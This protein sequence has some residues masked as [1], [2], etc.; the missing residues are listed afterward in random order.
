MSLSSLRSSARRLRRP[1]LLLCAGALFS[2]CEDAPT[3]ASPLRAIDARP[4]MAFSGDGAVEL[5]LP[6][7][8]WQAEGF[9]VNDAGDVVGVS[10]YLDEFGGGRLRATLWRGTGGAPVELPEFPGSNASEAMSI[11]DQGDIVGRIWHDDLG[12]N[13]VIWPAGGAPRALPGLSSQV[14]NGALGLSNTEVVGWSKIFSGRDRAT[15]WPIDGGAPS[16]LHS[17]PSPLF[18]PGSVAYDVNNSGVAVGSVQ[19]GDIASG[20]LDNPAVFN[21]ANAAPVSLRSLGGQWGGSTGIAY[22]INDP[23]DV[24][25]YSYV[26]LFNAGEWAHRRATLWPGN[27]LTEPR[28]LG[29]VGGLGGAAFAINTR[30]DIVGESGGRFAAGGFARATL[31]RANGGRPPQDLGGASEYMTTARSISSA[32]TYAAGFA[33]LPG[34][35]LRAVRFVLGGGG[36]P[37]VDSDGDGLAD[38]VDPEPTTFSSRLSDGAGGGTTSGL[39]TDRGDQQLAITDE[40][41][42]GVRISASPTGGAD[43]A[44]IE[45]C[46]AVATITLTPGDV[47]VATCGSVILSVI[48]GT[49][50]V[51]LVA[52][53]DR[54]G[55]ASIGAEHGITF[56]PATFVV[57]APASN[58]TTMVV[59]V[60]N[61]PFAVNPGQT[62][63]LVRD[64]TPPRLVMHDVTVP[65]TGPLG[66]LATY[67]V[68][69]SDDFDP[70]PDVHCAPASGGIFGIGATIVTC[71][72]TDR[73]GN[74][75]SGTLSVTIL[76]APQQIAGMILRLDDLT[77]PPGFRQQLVEKL[78]RVRDPSRP[79]RDSCSLLTQVAAVVAA[80]SRA[81]IPPEAAAQLLADAARIA[82][83]MS[84]PTGGED[85]PR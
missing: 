31:W 13:A 70:H 83:V 16:L 80:T 32:S 20:F 82:A 66:A 29:T 55:T 46:D 40:P 26:P 39:V 81:L 63:Q 60:R 53:G 18:P 62:V 72:A 37:S 9:G 25:G 51:R 58:P 56:H 64:D 54:I 8:A 1:T 74:T 34:G 57:E 7:G 19:G 50:E 49:L 4:A 5:P 12:I 36:G 11:N 75:G 47:A 14:A 52:A 30:G 67:A 28:D 71:T 43:A 65:A 35:P 27:D 44:T 33:A 22:G 48:A 2:A 23:G 76:G 21:G 15:R 42:N 85:R 59:T 61:N 45:L 6:P 77:L 69:A 10:H 84:C 17:S 79:G 73:A 68:S 38:A 3:A 24:V 78:D 41:T